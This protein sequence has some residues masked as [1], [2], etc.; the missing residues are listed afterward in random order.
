M[1]RSGSALGD[2]AG[3]GP[4]AAVLAAALQGMF[5]AY[6]SGDQGPA[7][8]LTRVN[9]TLLRHFVEGR[10]A[11]M[12]Y[13]ILTRDGR[14]MYSNAG[15]N[16]PMLFSA[17]RPGGTVRRLEE[18]GVPLG[19]F[20]DAEFL[21]ETLQLHTGDV[22]VLFSDGVSEAVNAA[23]DPFGDEGIIACVSANLGD[24]PQALLDRLLATTDA[25]SGGAV[26]QDDVTSIILRYRG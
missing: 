18:G 10:F 24:D 6:A 3:K 9:V 19:L 15:H 11:T 5:A 2:V 26:P 25:F 7:D 16:P 21:E 1:A 8:T 14:L 13:G 22:L 12:V 17:G 23:G 4:P 20:P